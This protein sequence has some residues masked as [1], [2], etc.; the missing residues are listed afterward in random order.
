MA[1]QRNADTTS[2]SDVCVCVRVNT[3][4]KAASGIATWATH[5]PECGIGISG[6]RTE[7][8]QNAMGYL[9]E[10]RQISSVFS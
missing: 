9:C 6:F 5:L 4:L 1:M 8:R 2:V 7:E 10:T 3:T